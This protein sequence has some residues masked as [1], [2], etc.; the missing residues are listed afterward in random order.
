MNS[1]EPSL[2]RRKILSGLMKLLVF[3]GLA[4]VSV[5][6]ISSLLSTDSKDDSL[7]VLS[8]AMN[9]LEPGQLQRL[10]WSG[11]VVWVY[12]RTDSDLNHLSQPNSLLVDSLSNQSDQP[13][14]LK[15][16]Y[17]SRDKQFFVF[18]PH[19]NKRGCQVRL[20]EDTTES[21]F[22][23]PCYGAQFDAAGRIIKNSGHIEQQ[24][25]AVPDHV[26]ED[27]NIRIGIWTPKL[28]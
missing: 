15:T 23:E 7:W 26:I 20:N 28:K 6:F 18:I 14:D 19:E 11:G 12:R 25:L 4:F 24:N 17:R 13:D 8:L 3:I 1:A 9:E 16:I 21:V 5:P 2:E 27:E 22:S 10:K